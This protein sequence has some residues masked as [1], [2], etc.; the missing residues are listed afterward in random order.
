LTNYKGGYEGVRERKGYGLRNI[1]E[2]VKG[3]TCVASRFRRNFTERDDIREIIFLHTDSILELCESLRFIEENIWSPILSEISTF[4]AVYALYKSTQCNLSCQQWIAAIRFVWVV[5]LFREKIEA[6]EK[7][8]ANNNLVR[9]TIYNMKRVLNT[10]ESQSLGIFGLFNVDIVD[11]SGVRVKEALIEEVAEQI[12]YD[13]RDSLPAPMDESV[14]CPVAIRL[15][16]KLCEL[17]GS[18]LAFPSSAAQDVSSVKRSLLERFLEAAVAS[19]KE[20]VDCVQESD[21]KELTFDSGL[22]QRCILTGPLDE[23]LQVTSKSGT[24]FDLLENSTLPK[25]FQAAVAEKLH[26]YDTLAVSGLESHVDGRRSIPLEIGDRCVAVNSGCSTGDGKLRQLGHAYRTVSNFRKPMSSVNE[27]WYVVWQVTWIVHTFAKHFLSDAGYSLGLLCERL[28]V[29]VALAEFA[30][31]HGI[32]EV[33][34]DF[35]L[36]FCKPKAKMK[37]AKKSHGAENQERPKKAAVKTCT[38]RKCTGPRPCAKLIYEGPPNVNFEGGWP[39]GWIQRT[40]ER[41]SGSTVGSTDHYW[42][43][44]GNFQF[45]FRSMTQIKRYLQALEICNGNEQEAFRRSK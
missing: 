21:L 8:N 38:P 6:E 19:K 45:K 2:G 31:Q 11:N 43:P 13:M 30:V 33:E 28:G 14:Y 34:E 35:Y 5:N 23:M 41:Q 17:L 42:F 39:E 12:C 1:V 16:T 44:N 36:Q 26:F 25:G 32:R 37:P 7:S 10:I 27:T 22:C 3:D 20:V 40:Y 15:I 24:F 4:S 9:V 18:T 29:D